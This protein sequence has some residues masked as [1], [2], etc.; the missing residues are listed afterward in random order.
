MTQA[1]QSNQLAE[2]ITSSKVGQR[3]LSFHAAF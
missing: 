3:F 1:F 2:L